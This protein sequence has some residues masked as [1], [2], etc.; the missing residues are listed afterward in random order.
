[1]KKLI[2]LPDKIDEILK[3]H[4]EKTGVSV[5]AYIQRAVYL[6]MINDRLMNIKPVTV[7]F[8]KNTGEILE[9][10]TIEKSDKKINKVPESIKYCDGDKCQVN[11]D[12]NCG[13]KT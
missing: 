13:C 1:M 10:V 3:N 2:T 4:K 8:N 6:Q 11:L 5:T 12:D 9:K 7:Y